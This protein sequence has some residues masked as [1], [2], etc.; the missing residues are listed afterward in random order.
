MTIRQALSDGAGKLTGC[1]TTPFLDAILLLCHTVGYT[2]EKLLSSY[3]DI[4]QN[5]ACGKYSA[6]IESRRAGEPVAYIIGTK[7]FYGLDFTIDHR[8]LVPRPDTEVLVNAVID[9][10]KS[11]SQLKRIHDCCTGSGCIAISIQHELPNLVVSASD[12]S[13]E[14]LALF[15]RNSQS[16]LNK[17]I[18]NSE[19]DLLGSIHETFDIICGNPPYLTSMDIQEKI[20]TNWPEPLLALDGGLDGLD[21]YRKLIP[22]CGLRLSKSGYVLLEADPSQ[23]EELE[24]LLVQNGFCNIMKYKDI[25]GRSRVIQ[26]NLLSEGS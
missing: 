22:Q 20:N 15:C 18:A 14:A 1:S 9:L 8:A 19:S 10:C 26:G 23:M 12:I 17:V 24:K 2:K 25:T 5:G 7:E 21:P 16:I 13:K 6:R 3:P 11:Q 4:L